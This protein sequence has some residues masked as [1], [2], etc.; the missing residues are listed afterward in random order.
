MD[1]SAFLSPSPYSVYGFSPQELSKQE[2]VLEP[3]LGLLRMGAKKIQL[4][5]QGRGEGLIP[6]EK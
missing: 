2:A 1:T 5:F 6:K 4:D 3:L